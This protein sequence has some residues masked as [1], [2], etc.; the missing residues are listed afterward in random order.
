[1]NR[2]NFERLQ[3]HMPELKAAVKILKQIEARGFEAY[4]V[5]GAVRDFVLG[6]EPKDIDI[7]TNLPMASIENMFK[8][9]DIGQSKSFGIVTALVDGF[10]F[11]VA[12]F[13][14]DGEYTDGRRPDCV[15]ICNTFEEDAARRD[16]CFNAMGMDSTGKVVDFFEGKSDLKKKVIRTVGNPND[17]FEED[18]I[19]MM[20]A[21]RFAARMEFD[22]E[23][24][25]KNAIIKNAHRIKDTAIERVSQ[26][27]FKMAEQ[28]GVKFARAIR[29]LDEVS[30]LEHI[31]PEV[32]ALKGWEH[33]PWHPEGDPFEHTIASIEQNTQK[34]SLVNIGVLLHD[35]GKATTYKNRGGRHTFFGHDKAGVSIIE[36]I[37]CR[38]RFSKEEKD[39]FCFATENHMKFHEICKGNMKTSKIFALMQN[40]NWNVLMQVSF[41]DGASRL[42]LFNEEE[43]NSTI[44]RL[45]KIEEE[46]N[47][48]G[49][50]P[51]LKQVNGKNIMDLTGLKPGKEIGIIVSNVKEWIINEC[52]SDL[53]MIDRKII[54]VAK[55]I[56]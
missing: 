17:R 33:G 30:L 10:D 6:K 45:K 51:A 49:S 34:N 9:Y 42:H 22:I 53:N 31:L 36:E 25:T 54:S 55:S 38:M 19:R 50:N 39:A 3:R 14:T 44:E 43:W 52:V 24:N 35:V 11:E 16:F 40:K 21:V 1:M 48:C 37:A 15:F 46:W 26:E 18:F 8:C 29:L 13:R 5:G 2:E 27:L 20:R 12:N 47:P 32:V 56:G 4:I 7:A 23:E 41:C 28:S